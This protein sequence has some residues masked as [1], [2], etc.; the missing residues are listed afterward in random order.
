M[1]PG[2]G[3][4]NLMKDELVSCCSG[5]TERLF[6]PILLRYSSDWS[7]FKTVPD[8]NLN[9]VHLMISIFERVEN[10][11]GIGKNA[12]FLCFL[13]FPQCFL[14]S[15]FLRVTKT[16]DCVGNGLPFTKEQI[17]GNEQIQIFSANCF[18]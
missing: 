16:L 13:F 15:F 12:G 10:I 9:G 7:E 14:K 4:V 6:N 5:M 3:I 2:Q 18:E 17:F 1:C 11:L 8:D